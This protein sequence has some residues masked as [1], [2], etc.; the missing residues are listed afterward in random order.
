MPNSRFKWIDYTWNKVIRNLANLMDLTVGIIALKLFS[1]Y[2][3]ASSNE[4]N[5]SCRYVKLDLSYCQRRISL[6]ENVNL[7]HCQCWMF[8]VLWFWFLWNG[9]FMWLNFVYAFL[10]VIVPRPRSIGNLRGTKK[11]NSLHLSNATFPVIWVDPWPTLTDRETLI[12]VWIW[13]LR[14]TFFF[15]IVTGDSGPI[16]RTVL[17]WGQDSAISHQRVYNIYNQCFGERQGTQLT[18]FI[19]LFC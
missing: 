10:S 15:L 16:L 18:W 4:R 14:S 19:H 12:F 3:W 11:N 1:V 7:D 13:V 6:I 17:N 5:M 2:V 9:I 8:L